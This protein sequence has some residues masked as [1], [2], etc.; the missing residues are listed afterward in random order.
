MS[1]QRGSMMIGINI[2]GLAE[3]HQ[4][5]IRQIGLWAWMDEQSG[6]QQP[7][8]TPASVPAPTALPILVKPAESITRHRRECVTCGRVFYSKRSDA[9]YH[10]PACRQKA[11]YRRPEPNT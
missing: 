8:R 5:R 9:K 3:E 1:E 10:S 6:R 11:H 4:T 7:S 2:D